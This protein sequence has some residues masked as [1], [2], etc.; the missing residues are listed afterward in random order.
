[1]VKMKLFAQVLFLEGHGRPVQVE[2]IK[3]QVERAC[4]FSA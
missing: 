2:N 3:P 1:M 4:G